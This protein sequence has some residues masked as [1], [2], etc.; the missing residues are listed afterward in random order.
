M[1]EHDI[2]LCLAE[3]RS[4]LVF[5]NFHTHLVS[6]DLVTIFQLSNTTDIQT[7]RS[8][9]FQCVTTCRRFRVSE[10]YTDLITQLVDEDTGR[11]RLID[12]GRQLTKGLRH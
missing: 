6:L 5:Y 11:I 8:I 3:W 7:D 9:E 2:E 12:R 1:T 10:H 4:H